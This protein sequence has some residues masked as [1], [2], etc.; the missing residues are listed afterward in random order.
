MISGPVA[1][2]AE[3]L[4]KWLASLDNGETDYRDTQDG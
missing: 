4:S 1:A 2:V 3:V